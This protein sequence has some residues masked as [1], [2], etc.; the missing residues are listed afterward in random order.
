MAFSF[1]FKE[2]PLTFP[3][4]LVV[5]NSISLCLSRK[6]FIPLSILSDSL[7]EYSI[8]DFKFFPFSTL[9]ISCSC[10]LVCNVSAANQLIILRDFPYT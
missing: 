4:K 5:M 6:L 2:V 7:V 10:H 3:V 1:S 8:F 9:N